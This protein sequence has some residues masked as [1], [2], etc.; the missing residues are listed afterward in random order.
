MSNS[1]YDSESK[2][3]YLILEAIENSG[4]IATEDEIKEYI[5][6]NNLLPRSERN[7]QM[8]DDE[9]DEYIEAGFLDKPNDQYIMLS[10]RIALRGL[11]L[12]NVIHKV[13]K[14]FGGRASITDIF[15]YILDNGYYSKEDAEDLEIA[16]RTEVRD[17][18]YQERDIS[19]NYEKDVVYLINVRT[20]LFTMILKAI[21]HYEG[22]A[23][24]DEIRSYIYD[25]Y[26]DIYFAY[27]VPNNLSSAVDKEL[28]YGVRS[29]ILLKP[30]EYDNFYLVNDDIP[31]NK[32]YEYIL[33]F[34][35]D[36]DNNFSS[37]YL[38][39]HLQDYLNIDRS[40]GNDDYILDLL[41]KGCNEY[42]LYESNPREFHTYHEG[43]VDDFEDVLKIMYYGND[44]GHLYTQ[45]EIF[46]L[47]NKKYKF[48]FTDQLMLMTRNAINASVGENMLTEINGSYS[49]KRDP[50]IGQN[51]EIYKNVPIIPQYDVIIKEIENLKSSRG[52]TVDEII[53]YVINNYRISP[54]R[55][56][57]IDKT[58]RGDIG[59]FITNGL[60][61][62]PGRSGRIYINSEI[63]A[64]DKAMYDTII[65]YVKDS[66]GGVADYDINNYIY[67]E[68]YDI[69][70]M[71]R[72]ALN[73]DYKEY[74]DKTER[75][76][77][78]QT[79]VTDSY[80]KRIINKAIKNN[81]LIEPVKDKI[82]YN[83]LHNI[84]K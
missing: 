33:K 64:Y 45:K 23:N 78:G 3:F 77:M 51:V 17:M 48:V 28:N 12:G 34:A 65:N 59:I 79:G 20:S 1:P 25:N 11:S 13:L 72:K 60:L 37:D 30:R 63:T 53:K 35:W 38:S 71:Y 2:H 6:K 4:E 31:Y 76:P 16:V 75:I 50:Y 26:D 7:N 29:G 52:A 32:L 41:Y 46:N 22:S 58:I 84:Q 18:E 81:V 74:N 61:S 67:D 24:I 73:N 62:Q 55:A 10:D 66:G 43:M 44:M 15:Y 8:L 47:V 54:E 40:D 80:I 14:H 21:K 70:D 19:Y 83:D 56:D 69:Y 42:F 36:L 27:E 57:E 49:V 82:Y 68:K 39:Y 5:F 9:I